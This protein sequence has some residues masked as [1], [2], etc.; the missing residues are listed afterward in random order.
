MNNKKYFPVTNFNKDKNK[1]F[2]TTLTDIES[3]MANRMAF[4]NKFSS[5]QTGCDL[6]PHVKTG[7]CDGVTGIDVP[8]WAFTGWGEGGDGGGGDEGGG[9]GGGTCAFKSGVTDGEATL[10][11][12]HTEPDGCRGARDGKCEWTVDDAGKTAAEKAAQ[13]KAAADEAA[14]KKAASDKAAAD[15]AKDDADKAAA[16]NPG[17]KALAD[18]AAA[19]KAKSDAAAV[20]KAAADKAVKDDAIASKEKVDGSAR[21]GAS[22]AAALL[23]VAVYLVTL[24]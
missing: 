15:K 6:S 5:V 1:A 21:L 10:C 19:A 2:T 7:R 3:I 8:N 14:A 9:G 18:E 20:T 12:Q 23:A 22:G 17:D 4:L 16:N 11:S 24:T 13:E